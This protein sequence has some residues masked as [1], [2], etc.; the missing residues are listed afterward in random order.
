MRIIPINQYLKNNGDINMETVRNTKFVDISEKEKN[1]IIK[2]KIA[3]NDVK[4]IKNPTIE[5]EEKKELFSLQRFYRKIV[6]KRMYIQEELNEMKVQ[7][8]SGLITMQWFGSPMKQS[9]AE[10]TYNLHIESYV[11]AVKQ[12]EDTKNELTKKYKLTLDELKGVVTDGQ[13]V[14]EIR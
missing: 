5:I 10:A 6:K 7:I 1:K 9:L 4:E 13:Y 12:E 2:E 8:D 3:K 14:K 11:D